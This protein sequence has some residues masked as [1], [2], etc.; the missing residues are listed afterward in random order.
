M[1]IN[2]DDN[3]LFF[4]LIQAKTYNV[5][6]GDCVVGVLDYVAVSVAHSDACVPQYSE[7]ITVHLFVSMFQILLA[8]LEAVQHGLNKRDDSAKT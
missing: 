6:G 5:S 4:S 7:R 3:V 1:G 8:R 2:N